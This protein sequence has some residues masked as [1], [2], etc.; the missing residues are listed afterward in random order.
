MGIF[1]WLASKAS[2]PQDEKAPTGFTP[3]VA[4]SSVMG[5]QSINDITRIGGPLTPLQLSNIICEADCGYIWRLIDVANEARAKDNHLQS[6]LQTRES[7]LAG[8]PW[9]IRPARKPGSTKA[10]NQAEAHAQFVDDAFRNAQGLP[11]GEVHS[12]N[13]L[14]NHLSS[15]I[16]YSFSVAETEY[17]TGSRLITPHGFRLIPHRRFAFRDRDG[18][19]VW[20]DDGTNIAQDRNGVDLTTAF[21]GKFITHQPRING[22]VPSREGLMRVL[23]WAAL[24]RNWTVSDWMKLA[25][26]AWKPWRTATYKSGASTKDISDIEATLQ[27]LVNNGYATFSDRVELNIEWASKGRDATNEHGA[28]AEFMAREMSKAVLGQ[29]LT[30]EEGERGA[31]SLGEV[32]DRVRLDL[33]EMDAVA[34]AATIRRDLIAPLVRMN[35]GPNALVPWFEFITQDKADLGATSRAVEGL[36]RAGLRIS[37]SQVRDMCGLRDPE[38]DEEI[39]EGKEAFGIVSPDTQAQIDSSERMAEQQPEVEEDAEPEL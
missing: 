10:T 13:T 6:V 19:L 24:F 32:H 16:F 9:K 39:L 29:T 25:E 5:N 12:F 20:R 1:S 22:D 17:E 15:A 36:V 4:S 11:G 31:R 33:M 18:K 26:L 7:V 8:M 3:P 34:L 38:P 37:A 14:I 28:L 30:T 35:F 2:N 21:P 27:N 23:L